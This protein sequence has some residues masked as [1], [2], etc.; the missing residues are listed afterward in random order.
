MLPPVA[1]VFFWFTRCDFPPFFL[2]GLGSCGLQKKQPDS[3][4]FE[5]FPLSFPSVGL[6]YLYMYE[7]CVI[8]YYIYLCFRRA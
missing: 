8:L 4:D 2:L 1:L 6:H 3:F 5:V 7:V